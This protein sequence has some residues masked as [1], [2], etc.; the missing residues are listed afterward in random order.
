MQA[1]EK[2]TPAAITRITARW[3]IMAPGLAN[4]PGDVLVTSPITAER[5]R[6]E[7]RERSQGQATL[8]PGAQAVTLGKGLPT[9]MPQRSD[10]RG[11]QVER[12]PVPRAGS[13]QVT[14]RPG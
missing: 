13:L 3:R 6:A 8:V 7:T 9:Q 5:D 12:A 4:V 1:E 2:A 11:S 10:A 14:Y